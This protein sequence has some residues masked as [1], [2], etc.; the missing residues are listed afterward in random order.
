MSGVILEGFLCPICKEDLGTISQL[1]THF[2]EA[3]QEEDR[4]VI[5]QLKGLFDKAKRK[6]LNNK[7]SGSDDVPFRDVTDSASA[8]G[9]SIKPVVWEPQDIGA[10]RSHTSYMKSARETRIDHFVLET[11]KLLIRLDK[12]L[13]GPGFGED[14]S[15]RKAFEKTVVPWVSDEHVNLCPSCGKGFRMMTK[16]R[17]HCRLCGGIMCNDCSMFMPE[18][19]AKKL[20]NPS[21]AY[22]GSGFR[23][24][25][26]VGSLNSGLGPEGE[27]HVR[28][29]EHCRIMLERRDHQMSQ[30]NIKPTIVLLYEK[31]RTCMDEI[32]RMIPEYT[33]MA[34][35]L[36]AGETTYTL[37]VASGYR[38]K[39][40]KLYEN[41]DALSKRILTLGADQEITSKEQQLQRMIR[42][43][44]TNFMQGNISSLQNLPTEEE[45]L[46]LQKQ[47]REEIQRKIEEEKQAA[48]ERERRK[49]EMMMGRREEKVLALKPKETT[50]EVVQKVAGWKPLEVVHDTQDRDPMI[51]QMNIIRGYIKQAKQ[52][53][54]W[55]EVNML[56]EN[57]KMLQQEYWKQSQG[58]T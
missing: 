13:T 21:H 36:N 20:T 23:R 28:T 1:T 58:D 47:R 37:S 17:H 6:L 18:S 15:K 50:S 41:V 27:P 9:G 32:E 44:A 25:S 24:S 3:H 16:R 33:K 5:N 54:K 19:Y 22:S 4:A 30:R 12:L 14:S 55:D 45:L 31:M 49:Q 48:L 34:E 52:L 38:L 10:I 7:D 39:V 57:L 51:Q 40:M 8:G 53:Q 29:C 26:S 11:N 46:K 43:S 35:A 42:S 2:D 56:E